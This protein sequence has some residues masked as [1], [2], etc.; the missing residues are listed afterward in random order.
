MALPFMA[1]KWGAN[2][3]VVDYGAMFW[4]LCPVVPEPQLQSRLSSIPVP[5]SGCCPRLEVQSERGFWGG[6]CVR[7]SAV[8]GVPSDGPRSQ[9]Q[10]RQ[11]VGTLAIRPRGGGQ[12]MVSR[13]WAVCGS[14]SAPLI[15]VVSRSRRARR[16]ASASLTWSWAC[17]SSV[18]AKRLG[19]TEG[20]PV[21]RQ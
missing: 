14:P 12:R 18:V 7:H 13:L 19:G 17:S 20:R 3:A 2:A 15:G 16:C 9:L 6:P 21:S 8:D 11:G 5:R 10:V 4:A 1:G